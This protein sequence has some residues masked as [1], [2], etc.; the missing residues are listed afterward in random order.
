LVKQR[1]A[2]RAIDKVEE[3]IKQLRNVTVVNNEKKVNFAMQSK[4]R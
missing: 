3:K 4:K 1:G 2:E